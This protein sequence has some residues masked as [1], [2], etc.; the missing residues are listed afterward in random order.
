MRYLSIPFEWQDAVIRAAIT[1]KLCSF[2]ESGAIIAAMTTSIPEAADS[3]RN[4]DYRYC[5]L[6]DAYFVVHALNRLGVTKTMEDYLRYITN[7]TTI[8]ATAEDGHLQPVY[9]ITQ[10]SRLTEKEI[11]SLAGYRAMGPVRIGNQAYE[12]IQ[13]D[14]YGSVILAATQSFFDRRLVRPGTRRLFERLEKLG[15]L[16]VKLFQQPDAGMWELRNRERVHTYSSVM[17]WA[18]CDRL[19]KIARRLARD[20]DDPGLKSRA[21]YWS[22]RAA[23]MKAVIGKQAWNKEQKC[24]VSTFGGKEV[25]ASLLLLHELGFVKKT[26]RRFAATVRA[27]EKALRRGDH[28]FR[29]AASDDFGTPETAFNICTFW[30]IEA[31][32]ALGRTEEARTLFENMLSRRNHVGLL[33]EDLDP[34]TGE[35]W[36]NFPQTY[37]MVGLINAA[38]RLSKTWEEA[39]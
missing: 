39:F 11:G 29:Y 37:S 3:T 10:E 36:G 4:W 26:D 5:W 17:C 38:M 8:V 30:Y 16:A 19:A 28:M 31:L 9:G 24:F 23:D 22:K 12:H 32:A 2:E 35:L 13:N 25:D 14:V 21:R 15:E 7:I 34:Q 18:G 1:V 33:S 27:V 20:L 6:R